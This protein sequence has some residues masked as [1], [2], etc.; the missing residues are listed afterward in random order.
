M[1]SHGEEHPNPKSGWD[2]A[3]DKSGC[4]ISCWGGVTNPNFHELFFSFFFF[5]FLVLNP[6]LFKLTDV[7]TCMSQLFVP[8]KK[9]KQQAF[10]LISLVII[11]T[12]LST[13]PTRSCMDWSYNSVTVFARCLMD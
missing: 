12:C 9:A 5:F 2:L 13:R 11:G 10:L 6:Q 8:E 4:T 3:P 1:L 7:V